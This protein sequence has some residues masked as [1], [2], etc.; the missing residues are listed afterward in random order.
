M[1]KILQTILS[2]YPHPQARPPVISDRPKLIITLSRGLTRE[3]RRARGP[4]FGRRDR[5]RSGL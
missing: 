1:L 4:E 2:P 5:L 3:Q